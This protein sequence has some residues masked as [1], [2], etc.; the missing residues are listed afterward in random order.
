MR[1]HSREMD[2]HWCPA[3]L[4][5]IAFACS[6]VLSQKL[7]AG[8]DKYAVDARLSLKAQPESAKAIIT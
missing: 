8:M 1:P 2:G 7:E 6:P 5:N 3:V 4:P